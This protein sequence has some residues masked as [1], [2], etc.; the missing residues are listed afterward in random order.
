MFNI[1]SYTDESFKK[2]W[3]LENLQPLYGPDN[4]KKNGSV[5]SKWNNI[6]LAAQ[7]L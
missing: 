7:L 2:C 1:T 3:S 4:L 6:E 5:G